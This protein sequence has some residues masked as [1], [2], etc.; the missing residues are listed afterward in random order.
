MSDSEE[1]YI[2]GKLGKIKGKLRL[3]IKWPLYLTL[4]LLV[5]GLGV[6]LISP[7]GRAAH[8]NRDHHLRSDCRRP[9]YI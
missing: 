8:G 1:T 6:Y 5:A 9:V 4:L 7:A 3:Y 2:M